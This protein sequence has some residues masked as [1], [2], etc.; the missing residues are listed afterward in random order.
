MSPYGMRNQ[1]F[2]RALGALLLFAT[3]GATACG[4]DNKNNNHASGGGEAAGASNGGKAG[5]AG[6]S[7]TSAGGSRGG[8]QAGSAGSNP[9]GQGGK[10]GSSAQGGA[11]GTAIG[12]GA[13]MGGVDDMGDGGE[14]IGG[15]SEGGAGGVQVECGNGVKEAGEECEPT[16]T[17]TCTERCQIIST[18][19]CVDCEAAGAC[20]NYSNICFDNFAGEDERSICYEVLKCVRGSDCAD[21]AKTP[22]D[23]FCG[24]LTTQQ[25]QAAPSSGAGAPNGACA[26]IIREAM[27]QNGQEA[28]SAQVLEHLIHEIFPGG[29]ALAR[30][31]CDRQDPSCITVC[32]F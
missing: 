10:A 14:G 11:G 31:N 16:N 30:V 9:G 4:N 29:A 28:T 19:A 7:G 6:D 23:C 8:A 21:G 17:S 2:A 32:G 1:V 20:I 25:C 27:S 24:T 18:K 12:G 3:C 15:W 22:Q 26:P 5:N 13:G